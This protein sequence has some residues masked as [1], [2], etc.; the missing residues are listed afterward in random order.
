[1]LPPQDIERAF[2]LNE[3]LKHVDLIF[4]RVFVQ[5]EVHA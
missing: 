3:Q 1:V 2:D 4:D 5:Q